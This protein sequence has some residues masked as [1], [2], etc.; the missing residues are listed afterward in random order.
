MALSSIRNSLG[1]VSRFLQYLD[2]S[3]KK[4]TE[5]EIDDIEDYVSILNEQ[6]IKYATFNQ[7]ILNIHT[8]FCFSM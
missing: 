5:L 7:Y 6:D 8:F 3:N 2:E 4:V 1:Y